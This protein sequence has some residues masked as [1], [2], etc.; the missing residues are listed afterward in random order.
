MNVPLS[1]SLYDAT[2]TP[3]CCRCVL[4]A[5]ACNSHRYWWWSLVFKSTYIY[6]DTWTKVLVKPKFDLMVALV[7]RSQMSIANC[8]GVSLV[9]RNL[10]LKNRWTGLQIDIQHEAAPW[11]QKSMRVTLVKYHMHF[12]NGYIWILYLYVSVCLLWI[13]YGTMC[14][15]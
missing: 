4:W 14:D 9:E 12:V 8:M 10:T 5:E 13:Y 7:S 15:V 3:Y 11:G 6:I 1:K 2:V